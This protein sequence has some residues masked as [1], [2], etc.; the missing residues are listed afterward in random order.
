[1]LYYKGKPK[2]P[3]QFPPLLPQNATRKKTQGKNAI[4]NFL[5]PN[6]NQ[7]PKKLFKK[8]PQK[9]QFLTHQII[10]ETNVFNN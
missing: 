8:I 5:P 6:Q 9:P 7:K 4:L 3:H 1:L 10:V 2:V